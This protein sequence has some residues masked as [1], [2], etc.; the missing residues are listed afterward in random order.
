MG[1]LLSILI[2]AR[3]QAGVSTLLASSTATW[4]TRRAVPCPLTMLR[5]AALRS[6]FHGIGLVKLMGRQSGFIALQA[7]MASG[8]VDVVSRVGCSCFQILLSIFY[9]WAGGGNGR[10]SRFWVLPVCCFPPCHSAAWLFC[11]PPTIFLASCAAKAATANHLCGALA[12]PA[13]HH[14]LQQKPPRHAC[15]RIANLPNSRPHTHT[16]T[17]CAALRLLQ[18]LIPEVPFTLYGERG[19][20]AFLEKVLAEKGHAVVCVAEGAGQVGG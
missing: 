16:H 6:A 2:C 13:T 3:R 4:P 14:R 9:C 12:H 11:L 7:S 15:M 17:P 8:V 10:I 20:F 18:C 5:P 19:M 1:A